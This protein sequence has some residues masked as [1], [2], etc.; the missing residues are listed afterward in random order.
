MYVIGF[1]KGL[2][3]Q[4]TEESAVC[5]FSSFSENIRVQTVESSILCGIPIFIA[6]LRSGHG[7]E[8]QFK[9]CVA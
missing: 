4:G 6:N 8:T 9:A 5:M 1:E 2:C 7:W 3:S